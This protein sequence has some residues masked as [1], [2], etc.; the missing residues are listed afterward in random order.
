MIPRKY[1]RY[2]LYALELFLLY[3][4][5]G[6]P[7][8]LP[9]IYL[10]KPLLLVSAAVSAAAFELPYFSLFY[11]VACGLVIDVGTGGVMGL[12]SIVLGFI[13]YYESSWHDKYIKNSIYLVLLYSAVASVLVIGLKWFVF[14]YIREY[15]GVFDLLRTHYVMRMLYTWAVTPLVYLITMGVSRAFIKEKRKIKV[16]K[17]KRVPPS[18]RSGASRRRAKKTDY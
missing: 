13:C 4:I 2:A 10:A 15:D 7:G 16:R 6:T 5:E 14:C 9:E 3:V 11:A 12:S 18:Q 8:L 17:R 1:Y